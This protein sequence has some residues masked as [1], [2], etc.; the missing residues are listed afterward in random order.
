[1][2]EQINQAL[3]QSSIYFDPD[4]KEVNF[5]ELMPIFHNRFLN[6]PP[7]SQF[8]SYPNIEGRPPG[9][10]FMDRLPGIAVLGEGRIR[11]TCYA[12]GAKT[13]SVQD[14]DW[15]EAILLQEMGNGYWS[16]VFEN[17][18]P[19]FHF[20]N[21]YANG[22]RIL[23]PL[24]PIAYSGFEMMNYYEVPIPGENFYFLKSVPHGTVHR[25]QFFSA[26]EGK[27]RTCY[28]Y[29]PPFYEENRD[30][31]YPVLYLFH[32]WGES[33]NAWM[34]QGKVPYIMD[35]GISENRIRD[36]IIVMNSGYISTPVGAAQNSLAQMLV[37][38]CIPFLDRH[39]R[40]IS[41]P[42]GRMMAGSA[43]I[44]DIMCEYQDQF[45]RLG[46]LESNS[47]EDIG[48]ENGR[49]EWD[50]RRRQMREFLETLF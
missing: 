33:E 38:E 50:I 42:G 16:G 18:F 30:Q 7:G 20:Q 44:A 34:W 12:P 2:Q 4:N 27:F 28:V 10:V 43:W 31:R 14:E 22:N 11:I 3:T 15:N 24:M 19:G 32:A 46:V 23:N 1:M 48:L 40:T 13:V 26:I 45:C 37:E 8:D 39:Y 21:Y 29:T 5:P 35:N 9:N 47:A 36:M 6:F 49:H 41:M 17:I 25:N